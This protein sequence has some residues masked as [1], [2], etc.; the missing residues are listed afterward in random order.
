MNRGGR[1]GVRQRAA[2]DAV[3]QA[4]PAA[5][6]V[7]VM[8][9]A[10]RAIRPGDPAKDATDSLIRNGFVRCVDPECGGL[11]SHQCRVRLTAKGRRARAVDVGRWGRQERT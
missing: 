10:I 9:R 11:G 7:L 2:L 1:P 4:A 6:S 3:H 5:V 8:R